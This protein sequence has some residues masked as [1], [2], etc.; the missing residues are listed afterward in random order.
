MPR[1]NVLARTAVHAWQAVGNMQLLLW[2]TYSCCSGSGGNGSCEVG[3]LRCGQNY[4]T[5]Q[6]GHFAFCGDGER[7]WWRLE[8]TDDVGFSTPVGGSFWQIV[9][10]SIQKRM[11]SASAAA[12]KPAL[13][14]ASKMFSWTILVFKNSR[15]FLMCTI[16]RRCWVKLSKIWRSWKLFSTAWAAANFRFQDRVGNGQNYSWIHVLL[17]H[18]VSYFV[19]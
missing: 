4:L 6:W 8:H 18:G 11:D 14:L 12:L 13:A 9:A 16:L 5:A 19:V 7:R 1:K 3:W 15:T 10:I 17:R 2:H